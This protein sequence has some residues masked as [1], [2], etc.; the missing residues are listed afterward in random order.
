MVLHGQG[1]SGDTGGFTGSISQGF[2]SSHNK[3]CKQKNDLFLAK[4][5]ANFT[6]NEFEFEQKIELR[7]LF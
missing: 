5:K 4:K 3:I 6:I 1:F 2:R 7:G